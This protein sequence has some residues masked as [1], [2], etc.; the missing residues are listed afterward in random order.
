ML[1]SPNSK[2][3]V[4]NVHTSYLFYLKASLTSTKWCVAQS[5]PS[6]ESPPT[7]RQRWLL[8]TSWWCCWRLFVACYRDCPCNDNIWNK[9][10]V[11]RE[12]SIHYLVMSPADSADFTLLAINFCLLLSAFLMAEKSRML[13]MTRDTQGTRWTHTTRNLTCSCLVL[14]HCLNYFVDLNNILAVREQKNENNG[15]PSSKP[16]YFII[17][18]KERKKGKYREKIILILVKLTNEIL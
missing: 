8:S 11:I 12:V 2:T 14:F 4:E 5:S 9:P 7:K 18:K 1:E 3:H 17:R 13:R 10:R 16:Q 15:R 6:E